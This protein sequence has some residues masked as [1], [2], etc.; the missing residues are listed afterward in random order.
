[1]KKMKGLLLVGIFMLSISCSN[2]QDEVQVEETLLEN[3]NT[4]E[5]R[6][7]ITN[8]LSVNRQQQVEFLNQLNSDDIQLISSN[9]TQS[10]TENFEFTFTNSI[11]EEFSLTEANIQEYIDCSSC[12]EEYK[13][14]MEPMF[15]EFLT[16]EDN[17]VM[18]RLN[19]YEEL[20]DTFEGDEIVKE[21]L[22]FIF[23]SF[24]S[25]VEYI[26]NEITRSNL[27]NINSKEY[28]ISS[29]STEISLG[30][31]IGQGLVSGFIVGCIRGG[32][33]GAVAG[34]LAVPVI[35]TVTGAVGGCIAQGAV[36]GVITAVVG[37]FWWWVN[38]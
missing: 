3:L 1:M 11:P 36:T 31:A 22:H 24:K 5:N 12:N 9:F 28:I 30:R 20:I 21:N 17:Q 8:I 26:S 35:G 16:I 2:E 38:N 34:T 29:T 7:Y 32:I 13:N 18:D 27:S 14:F 6:E 19:Y 10:N 23:F 25:A 33:A 15:L 4:S 37:A